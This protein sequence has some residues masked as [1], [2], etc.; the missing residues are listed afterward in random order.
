MATTV[1]AT[2][3][4]EEDPFMQ[5]ARRAYP[6][7]ASSSETTP[8]GA[9]FAQ[10][11]QKIYFPKRKL[12]VTS[13]PLNDEY[14]QRVLSKTY[15]TWI[16]NARKKKKDEPEKKFR[17]I[18]SSLIETAKDAKGYMSQMHRTAG[19]YYNQILICSD[20]ACREI[21]AAVLVNE[22]KLPTGQTCIEIVNLVSNPNNV[23]T[24]QNTS[25]SRRVEGAARALL[26]HVVA[27]SPLEC[28]KIFLESEPSAVEFYQKYG[29]HLK[30]EDAKPPYP[31]VMDM[32]LTA[33]QIHTLMQTKLLTVKCYKEI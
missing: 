20:V 22:K 7:S 1:P 27:H 5:I 31:Q 11:P 30:D 15:Q 10:I 33:E 3:T 13:L 2:I 9:L 19:V 18:Y 23:R 6:R 16:E 32:T 26:D 29:F 8:A 24:Q 21:Q 14:T 28:K 17:L 25:E 12:M 4:I